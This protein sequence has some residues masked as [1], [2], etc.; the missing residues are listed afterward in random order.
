MVKD[1]TNV[2]DIF[3]STN[4]LSFALNA[5]TGR[6]VMITRRSQNSPFIDIDQMEVDAAVI[7]YG[8]DSKKRE[9]LLREYNITY[10]YWSN[11]WIRSEYYSNEK[12][13]ITN[14]FDPIL[15]KDIKNY[16]EYFESYNISYFSQNTWID[17]SIKKEKIRKYNLLF[18]SPKNYRS[19]EKP[20]YED[21]DNYLKEVWIYSYKNQ[22]IARIYK[23]S[24]EK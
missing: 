7:L 19:F 5:L 11:Y 8:K 23:V 20:W 13:E 17:P 4:E 6:K 3:I 22:T 1:N 12:G 2:N 9:E 18:V 21:L 10:L 14:W 24:Y 15:A 16:K